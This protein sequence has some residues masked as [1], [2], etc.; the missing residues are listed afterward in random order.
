MNANRKFWSLILNS[1]LVTV[2]GSAYA[3]SETSFVK[4][5]GLLDAGILINS[6]A[7]DNRHV[8][9]RSNGMNGNRLGFSG[10]ED[11]GGGSAAVFTLEIGFDGMTGNPGFGGRLFGAM[12]HVGFDTPYGSFYAGRQPNVDILSTGLL[13]AANQWAGLIGTHPGDNDNYYN[14]FRVANAL[15]YVSPKV[16][17]FQASGLYAPGEFAGDNKRGR[18]AAAAV[19]YQ[20]EG[21]KIAASVS[22]S[23]N[24]NIGIASHSGNVA[25]PVVS[26]TNFFNSPIVSG[27]ASAQSW[28]VA[29]VGV[30][31]TMGDVT[32]GAVYTQSEFRNLGDLTSGPNPADYFGDAR[33]RN[34]EV[35]LTYKV[36]PFWHLGAEYV[37]TTR[38]SVSRATQPQ[39]SGG[40][41]Y[42]LFTL[43]TRYYLAKTTFVYAAFGTMRATG[44]GSANTSAV[45]QINGAVA[46][47]TSSQQ[48]IRVGMQYRF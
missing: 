31:Y 40:A 7:P 6:H 9:A 26:T 24:P 46:S 28:N 8:Q 41:T 1:V 18:V 15:K 33:F 22:N 47:S 44:T 42:H 29:G 12:L 38:N 37:I 35:N 10:R 11:I 34:H 48:N 3:Q 30:N 16:A 14:T 13:G 39:G 45:A 21:L 25:A 4:I 20:H 36:T 2:C 19:S 5:Y 27:Y 17:G 43:A 32:L 23:Q